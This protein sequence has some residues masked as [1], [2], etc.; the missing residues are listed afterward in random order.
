[1]RF[2]ST[3]GRFRNEIKLRRM[4]GRVGGNFRTFEPHRNLGFRGGERRR[5]LV[6]GFDEERVRFVGFFWI[7]FLVFLECS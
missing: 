2:D 7:L 1:M 6:S 3:L 5:G 4:F